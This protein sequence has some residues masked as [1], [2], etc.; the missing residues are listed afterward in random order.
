M[1]N[2]RTETK[3]LEIRM[4]DGF[5]YNLELFVFAPMVVN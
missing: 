2:S 1:M 5:N 4:I 3:Y